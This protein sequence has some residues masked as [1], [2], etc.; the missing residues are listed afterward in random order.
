MS[1]IRIKHKKEA[2]SINDWRDPLY[3]N[4]LLTD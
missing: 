3:L 1:V 2:K 4:N